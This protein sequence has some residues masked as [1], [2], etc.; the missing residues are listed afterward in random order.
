MSLSDAQEFL[1]QMAS[2]PESAK[3]AA[4]AHRRQLIDLARE[5]G[6]EVTEQ[7]LDEA[8]RAARVAA[9]GLDDAALEAV[10]GGFDYTSPGGGF[11]PKHD[12]IG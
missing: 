12:T 6:F 1:Q 7:D 4:T 10:V 5:K 11:D 8:V 3:K 2:D 9:N